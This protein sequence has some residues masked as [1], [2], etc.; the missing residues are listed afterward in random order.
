MINA[1]LLDEVTSLVKYRDMRALQTVGYKELFGYLEGNI[2]LQDAVEQIK[3]NTRKYCK[4]QLTWFRKNKAI[5]WFPADDPS[6]IISF[7]E[8]RLREF[9]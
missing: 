5:N 3:N 7:I 6:K 9:Q 4:R 8:T 1:G 2:S